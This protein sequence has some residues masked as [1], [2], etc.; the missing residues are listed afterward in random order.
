M[1]H[2][3]CIA[4]FYRWAQTLFCIG[5]GINH[6]LLWR[7]HRYYRR[8]WHVPS[9]A[10]NRWTFSCRTNLRYF[11]RVIRWALWCIWHFALESEVFS[12]WSWFVGY[13][14][15]RLFPIKYCCPLVV[16][17]EI[18]FRAAAVISNIVSKPVEVKQPS[19]LELLPITPF[20]PFEISTK[21]FVEFLQN[22]SSAYCFLAVNTND[23]TIVFS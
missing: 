16:L 4:D 18:S 12:K 3:P 13:Q 14:K 1:D 7:K 11:Q 10:W 8:N 15:A 2:S 6:H 23:L 20:E 5:P 21:K 19:I 9:N 22:F 17:I